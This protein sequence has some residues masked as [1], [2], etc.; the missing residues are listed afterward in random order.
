M[1]RNPNSPRRESM[2]NIL[3]KKTA[4]RVAARTGGCC[5]YCGAPGAQF[6]HLHPR[7]LGGRDVEHNVALACAVC[8]RAKS[9]M[10]LA[11]W[12]AYAAATLGLAV[13]PVAIRAAAMR[14]RLDHKLALAA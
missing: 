9:A 7:H 10:T 1:A 3:G 13:D 12:A 6:D 11:Q 4:A 5:A 8:N 14:S 2:R